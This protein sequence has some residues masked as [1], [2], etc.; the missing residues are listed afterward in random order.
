[1]ALE[2]WSFQ[3]MLDEWSKITGKKSVFVECSGEDF[4]KLWGE[5][6]TELAAQFKLGEVCNPWEDT[7]EILSA[8]ELGIDV[9]EVVGFRGTIERLNHL[10]LF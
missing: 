10:G 9:N 2:I 8:G 1:M 6:G 4:T 5:T 3:Q 7:A